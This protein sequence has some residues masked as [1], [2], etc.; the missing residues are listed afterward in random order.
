MARAR[1]TKKLAQRID[2][3]YFKKPTP[4]KRAKLLLSVLLPVLAVTWIAWRGASR[5]AR[6][7]SSGRMSAAHAMLEQECGV[8][9][10]QVAGAFS[11]KAEDRACLACHDGPIHHGSQVST[12]NCATFARSASIVA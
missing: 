12:P 6:V 3:N 4:L 10:L 1:T 2:L 7:Y 8:C 11:A 5:D 9:H